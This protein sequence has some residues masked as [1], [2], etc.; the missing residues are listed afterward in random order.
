MW[1]V[2]DCPLA[3]HIS[4]AVWLDRSFADG[5]SQ[6]VFVRMALDAVLEGRIWGL[7]GFGGSAEGCRRISSETRACWN[8]LLRQ[9]CFLRRDSGRPNEAVCA[10]VA[11]GG[12]WIEH[13]FCLRWQGLILVFSAGGVWHER[14]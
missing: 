3:D 13:Y 5:L 10:R 2:G 12:M 1:E 8:L 9:R 14:T 7:V 4:H 6:H 11:G